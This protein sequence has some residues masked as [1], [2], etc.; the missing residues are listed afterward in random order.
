MHVFAIRY[1]ERN[2]FCDDNPFHA[3]HMLFTAP[4]WEGSVKFLLSVWRPYILMS[5]FSIDSQYSGD[6]FFYDLQMA[7]LATYFALLLLF[8]LFG[9]GQQ[10]HS[11]LKELSNTIYQTEWYRY[12]LSVQRSA[13]LMMIRS[14]RPFFL[15]VFGMMAL[16]LENFVGVSVQSECW[17][18]VSRSFD[19]NASVWFSFQL[20]KW[21]YSAFMLL[22]SFE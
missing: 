14:Q 13:Q 18:F 1:D 7:F 4:N 19:K 20:M 3:L 8:I 2:L 15:S 17:F 12:P 9:M 21:I 5:T 11:S 16:N 6:A 10:F 22:R